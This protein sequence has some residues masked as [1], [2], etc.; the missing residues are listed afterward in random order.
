MLGFSSSNGTSTLSFTRVGLSSSTS[1]FTSASLLVSPAL[2]PSTACRLDATGNA[3]TQI[4]T[5]GNRRGYGGLS[6]RPRGARAARRGSR[7][8]PGA[9]PVQVRRA[10]PGAPGPLSMKPGTLGGGN[11]RV[12]ENRSAGPRRAA[13]QAAVGVGRGIAAGAEMVAQR[14][15]VPEA[16]LLG[17]DVHR[18]VRL[19]Q[20][21]LGQQDALRS[22]PAQRRGPGFLGEAPRERAGRHVCAAGQVAD[23]QRPA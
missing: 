4:I 11:R 6:Y 13:E 16:H 14:S 7:G 21:L 3:G 20:Q 1:V 5:H 18:L 22:Q 12:G 19:L 8:Q 10:G 15:R 2:V 17:D 23:A 9:G